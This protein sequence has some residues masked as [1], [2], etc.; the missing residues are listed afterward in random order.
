MRER[1]QGIEGLRVVA[2]ILVAS[3]LSGV[4][5][6][7]GGFVGLDIGFVIAGF[8]ASRHISERSDLPLRAFFT[9]V[10]AYRLRRVVPLTAV[11]SILTGAFIIVVYGYS[12]LDSF[13]STARSV[14]LFYTDFQLDTSNGHPVSA[15]LTS[16]PFSQ[17]WT[18]SLLQQSIVVWAAAYYYIRQRA[19]EKATR[20]IFW[21]AM[22]LALL[23]AGEVHYYSVVSSVMAFSVGAMYSWYHDRSDVQVTFVHD[24]LASLGLIVILVASVK[25]HLGREYNG[26]IG[27]AIAL[28]TVAIIAAW[29]PD[30][31]GRLER[32]FEFRPLSSLGRYT[33]AFY[34]WFV[35][36]LVLLANARSESLSMS[37]RLL[38]LLGAMV[39]AVLSHHFIEVPVLK[40]LDPEDDRVRDEL[41]FKITY[42]GTAILITVTVLFSFGFANMSHYKPITAFR[43]PPPTALQ[44]A[45]PTHLDPEFYPDNRELRDLLSKVTANASKVKV[46]SYLPGASNL[47]KDADSKAFWDCTARGNDT[48]ARV[49]RVGDELG[50]ARILLIGDGR[51]VALA[52]SLQPLAAQE[53]AQMYVTARHGCRNNAAYDNTGNARADACRE[54][55]ANA[56]SVI[57]EVQ[58]D[59]IVLSFVERNP[60]SGVAT[61]RQ[62]V[63]GLRTFVRELSKRAG[64]VPVVDVGGWPSRKVSPIEC[65]KEN[66]RLNRCS[67]P[68]S[69]AVNVQRQELRRDIVKANGF[70]YI[71][72][73]KYFCINKICPAIVGGVATMA[74]RGAPSQSYMRFI[75]RAVGPELEKITSLARSHRRAV[76]ESPPK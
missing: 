55:R 63:G 66:V 12:H 27:V 2:M 57:S 36:G 26:F 33:F 59:V 7:T 3:W 70:R 61:D 51:A 42:R 60:R 28:S 50:R 37:W 62:W 46:S 14:I 69:V 68:L 48:T 8:F 74:N 44:L 76:N 43:A 38:V 56:L 35:P 16:S 64:D 18:I 71:S 29:A 54:W 9:D 1:I 34:L 32:I 24:V 30:G 41:D 58:P 4:G 23:A 53:H 11:V 65:L 72:M 31:A 40:W 52:A 67:T 39:L 45:F 6:F 17:F 13:M 10:I 49:C 47:V 21:I 25:L 75:T 19:S 20:T 22:A 73:T 5:P 15:S